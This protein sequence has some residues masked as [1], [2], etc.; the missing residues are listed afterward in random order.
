MENQN[1]KQFFRKC[2][3]LFGLFL[4]CICCTFLFVRAN[5]AEGGGDLNVFW[6]AGRN[7]LEHNA[8]YSVE[9]DSAW[10]FKYPPW[11]LPFFVPFGFLRWEITKFLWSLINLIL[12][13][14]IF[15]FLH[16]LL[17]FKYPWFIIGLSFALCSS[18]FISHFLLGQVSI[19]IL[20]FF[21]FFVNKSQFY[22]FC[23]RD[24][25]LTAVSTTKV[26]TVLPLLLRIRSPK[27]FII[28]TLYGISLLSLS[29]CFGILFYEDPH[30]LLKW[31][32]ISYSG[33]ENFGLGYVFGRYNHGLPAMF[34]RNLNYRFLVPGF[35]MVLSLLLIPVVLLFWKKMVAG[36]ETKIQWIGLI[37]IIPVIHPLAWWHH[38]VFAYPLACI[39]LDR[40]IKYGKSQWIILCLWALLMIGVLSTFTLGKTVGSIFEIISAKSWGILLLLWILHKTSFEVQ[41]IAE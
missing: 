25:F 31:I 17:Q 24:L 10:P 1:L 5:S 39:V 40:A 4:I 9:R 30:F 18:P 21:L 12:C 20:Y 23:W 27:Q 26:F 28:F 35:D 11:I 29:F 8:I 22:R 38:F 19:P 32:Q 2:A 34:I 15:V 3:N 7:F 16:S 14:R 33:A 37:A 41:E 6:R 36:K 13:L